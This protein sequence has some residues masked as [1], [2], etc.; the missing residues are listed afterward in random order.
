MSLRAL[1]LLAAG[2]LPLAAR[3]E[4]VVVTGGQTSVALDTATL[5][6]GRGGKP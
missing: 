1:T 3:A 6:A 2:V 4:P 5:T